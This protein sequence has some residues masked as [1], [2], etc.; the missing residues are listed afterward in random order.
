MNP[1]A[2]PTLFAPVISD[3]GTILVAGLALLLSLLGALIGLGFLVR[4]TKQWIGSGVDGDVHWFQSK[5]SG[6]IFAVRNK[7]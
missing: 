3:I 6:R 7:E 1:S 5:T 2:I 4:R